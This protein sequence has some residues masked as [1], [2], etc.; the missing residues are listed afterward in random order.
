MTA[1]GHPS[2][3][4]LVTA[5]ILLKFSDST[6]I[7]DFKATRLNEII[8]TFR[9]GL[10][11]FLLSNLFW[12]SLPWS[13]NLVLPLGGYP[14]SCRGVE[15]RFI[16]SACRVRL[17]RLLRLLYESGN[18]KHCVRNL[19]GKNLTCKYSRNSHRR[20]NILTCIGE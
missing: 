6:R 2:K 18:V 15:Y 5:Q 7:S 14:H 10:N 19:A 12:P 16:S 17:L 1:R 20:I 11:L 3:V 9:L 4:G 13:S 8:I